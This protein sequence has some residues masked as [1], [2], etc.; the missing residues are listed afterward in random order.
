MTIPMAMTIHPSV[1][2]ACRTK[3]Q[4]Q[5]VQT[6]P[7][8]Q[9]ELA[10]EPLSAAADNH[11]QPSLNPSLLDRGGVGV[12]AAA[13]AAAAIFSP[14]SFLIIP[15]KERKTTEISSTSNLI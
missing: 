12:A 11:W 5:E 7:D 10:R 9:I 6:T 3:E 1:L 15:R 2:S 4:P 13:A 8:E 14:P